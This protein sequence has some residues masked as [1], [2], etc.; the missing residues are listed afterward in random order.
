MAGDQLEI[1]QPWWG[2]ILVCQKRA[3]LLF[4]ICLF[5]LEILGFKKLALLPKKK[6]RREF[7]AGPPTIKLGCISLHFHNSNNED[8]NLGS[9]IN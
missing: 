8:G 7:W 5:F 1:W 6:I 9:W 4:T 3:S 2:E